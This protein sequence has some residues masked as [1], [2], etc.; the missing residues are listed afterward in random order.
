MVRQQSNLNTGDGQGL[1]CA[2]P[3]LNELLELLAQCAGAFKQSRSGVRAINFM[4]GLLLA[5]SRKTCMASRYYRNLASDE[6]ADYKV[7]SRS[8]WDVRDWFQVVLKEVLQALPLGDPLVVA[9]D[10]TGLRK[11]GRDIPQAR[12]IYDPLALKWL[13]QRFAWGIRVLHLAALIPFEYQAGRPYA[14]PLGFYP[15]PAA[16][17]PRGKG[18]GEEELAAYQAAK[19]ATLLTTEGRKEIAFLRR[20]MDS[21][22][23]G[24]RK[25]IVVVDGSFMNGPVAKVPILGVELIGRVRS[26]IRLREKC[27]A[28][29]GRAFYGDPL[30]TP[31]QYRLSPDLPP[32]Q[33]S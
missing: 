2:T 30:P 15:K 24:F 13:K 19:K 17:K 18:V 9:M 21:L 5:P 26:T 14:I 31:E 22:D 29:N 23:Q 7:F 28:G 10:D 6:S 16:K 20:S 25:L 4:L 12:Y 27:P 8:N 11:W 3:I 1:S 33:A 32:R